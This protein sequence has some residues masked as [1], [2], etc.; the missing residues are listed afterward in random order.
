MAKV[1]NFL[2]PYLASYELPK[3]D[4]QKDRDL[5]VTEIL[6]KGDGKALEW[7]TKNYSKRDVNEVVSSPIKGMWLNTNL[8]YWL[9]ILGTKLSKT[10]YK[11]AIIN[12]NT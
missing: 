9:N 12:F 2:Q 1:P 6:N 10:D 7:L 5:I 11:N 4:L 3:L 8:N